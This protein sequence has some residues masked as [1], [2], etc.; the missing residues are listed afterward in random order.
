MSPA[1]TSPLAGIKALAFDVFGTVVDW[2][3]SVVD[4]LSLRAHR[5]LLDQHSPPPDLALRLTAAAADDTWSRFAQAWRD[6]YSAFTASFDPSRDAWKSIDRHHRDSLVA[7]LRDWGFDGLYSDAETDSLSLVWHRLSP[8]PDSSDGLRALASTGKLV[9]AT[10]SNGNLALLR[11]LDDFGSLGFDRLLSAEMFRAYKPNP[12]T[13]LGAAKEL[14]LEPA[15]VAMVAAHLGDLKAARACG[16][17]T[18]YVERPQEEAWDE[19]GDDYRQA[20]EWVDLWISEQDDGLLSL[21]RRLQQLS[22]V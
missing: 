5:K 14:G 13:Y 4:E 3:T 10:L 16:L 2:R 7:L 8:W 15:Q 6:S 9:T 1:T 21:A 18:I 19:D 11:D 20:R 12:A 17:R 22:E